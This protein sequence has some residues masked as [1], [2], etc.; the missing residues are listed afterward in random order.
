MTL[1]GTGN[2]AWHLSAALAGVCTVDAV[3]SRDPLSDKAREVARR[4]GNCPCVTLAG[5]PADSDLYIIAASDDA[6]PGIAAA[7][8]A[9]TG[10][11]THTSGSVDID[12]LSAVRCGGYGSFYPLQ[13]FTAGKSVDISAIPWFVEGNTEAVTQTLTD[14][15]HL[16]TDSVYAADSRLRR[17]IHLAAVLSS[18]FAN[19]LLAESQK[20]L[21]RVGLP[22]S[23]LKPLM[24]ET[25]DKAFATSPRQAQTGPARRGDRRTMQRH[26]DMLAATDG[27]GSL[28]EIYTILS[29]LIEKQQ[30]QK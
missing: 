8:P 1:V 25:M 12:A 30:C 16:L 10:I 14:M 4:A 6:I 20:V 2:V 15:A 18:N 24:A 3:V 9:V 22:L 29:K 19:A 17:H 13:T 26:L 28:S 23:V 21:E 11:V 5:M 27:D 7:M